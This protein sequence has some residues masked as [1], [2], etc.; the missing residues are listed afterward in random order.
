[1]DLPKSKLG[2]DIENDFAPEYHVIAGKAKVLAEIKKAAKDKDNVYLA[3]DPDR[4]GEAIAW[5]IAREARLPEAEEHPARPLQRDHEE[6]RA[7]GDPAPARARPATSSTRSRRAASS[8]GW[9]ATSSR[10]CS[11]RRCAAA[12]RPGACSRSPCASSSS[13]S[14]R[15][16]RSTRR[17]T[18]RSRR[19]SRA[20]QPPP[21]DARLAEVDGKKLDPRSFRLDANEAQCDEVLAGLSGADWT[22]TKVETKERRRNPTPPFITSRLQQEASR[23]LGFQPT[24]TMRIAQRLYEGVELGDEG[25]VGLITYMRTDSTRV[26][27]DAHRGRAASSSATRYGKEYVPEQPNVYRSKKDAQDAH[28]AI[29]PTS[30]EYTPER[31][32]P[33]PRARGA[34]PLHADLEPLRR[35]PDGVRRLRPDRRRHRGA[36]TAASAPPG[37]SSS[38]TASSASTPRA[39]TTRRRRAARTRTP[40]ASS[41]RS[42]RA[43]S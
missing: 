24:R 20:A 26:S 41:R 13:A 17:S 1:M 29:R 30:M 2:V 32:A 22:V 9:S 34:P 15:S 31:V 7:G 37:R 21:F 11:G 27:A 42:S 40:R 8:T 36:R 14:A 19:G 12:C 3:P 25:A 10:R 35:E 28:E 43:R 4:E 39:A 5:H 38:S 33:L 6:G 16:A 18:G 23:K